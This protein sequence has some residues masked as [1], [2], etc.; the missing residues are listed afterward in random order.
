MFAELEVQSRSYAAERM[1]DVKFSEIRSILEK[2]AGLERQGKEVIH[3]EIGRPDFLTPPHIIQ[4]AKDALEKGMVHYTSNYGI[5]EL[6][7]AIA[8]KLARENGLKADPREEIIVTIGAAEAV[9]L[10]LISFLDPGD[11]VLVPDPSWLNYFRCAAMIG[12]R[13]VSVPLSPSDGWELD[14]DVLRKLVSKRTKMLILLSPHNPTGSVL[15][16]E[17]L[18][19]IADFAIEHDLLVVSDEIYERI[20]YDGAKH[21]SIASLPGMWARTITINGFSKAYSMTG[22][23]LGYLVAAKPLA[24]VLIRAHQYVVTSATSFAQAGAVIAYTSS[25]ECVANMVAEFDRRRG[26]V[27]E[28]L[29]CIPGISCF[30]PRGG[31][32]AFPSIKNTGLSSEEVAGR[33]LTDGLV[34]VVPGT[35]FGPNGEGYIRI[36]FANSFEK[37]E[38]GLERISRVILNL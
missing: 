8:E 12:A 16:E 38:V 5:L 24:Q 25:Q 10:A 11:E 13:A 23:R 2:A 27:I 35:T 4:A 32:Y 18:R 19:A 3:L 20:I 15:S 33:I 7:Q 1:K 9:F 30:C 34:A 14:P 21:I 26:L 29:S 22:W 31:F 6:R 17:R 28:K 36:S 37:L